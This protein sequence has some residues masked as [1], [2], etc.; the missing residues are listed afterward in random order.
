MR[1]Q[2]RRRKSRRRLSWSLLKNGWKL[3]G[4]LG[5]VEAVVQVL[6][7]GGIVFAE[8]SDPEH[9]ADRDMG[10][11]DR[12]SQRRGDDHRD[13]GRQRHAI[14]PHRVHLGDLLA[15]HDDQFGP[16]QSKP[17]HKE[18]TRYAMDAELKSYC[19]G[20]LEEKAQQELFARLQG[21]IKKLM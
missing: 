13:P 16:E 17:D 8:E 4:A 15:D 11:A 21:A 5:A 20:P 7:P 14:G 2:T 18:N 12:Q 3:G 6:A 10:G 9:R 1:G 19:L